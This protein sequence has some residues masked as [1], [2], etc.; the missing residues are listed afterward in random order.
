MTTALQHRN[1]V[2]EDRGRVVLT[3][4][5]AEA[6]AEPTAGAGVVTALLADL[7]HHCRRDG[8]SFA[9]ALVEAAFHFRHES[10][11]ED[12]GRAGAGVRRVDWNSAVRALVD[13]IREEER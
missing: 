1:R 5:A 13:E 3:G 8:I 12:C 4:Y 7:M 6:E 9:A 2:R 10:W 11:E